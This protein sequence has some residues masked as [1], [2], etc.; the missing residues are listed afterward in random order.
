MDEQ[1]LRDYYTFFTKVWRYFRKNNHPQT[2]EEWEQ[3]VNDQMELMKPYRN[4]GQFFISVMLAVMM[5][6][7]RLNTPEGVQRS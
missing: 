2:E 6:I 4:K 7:E 3:M 1:T 5:E